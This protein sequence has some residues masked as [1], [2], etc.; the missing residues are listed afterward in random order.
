[1]ESP[2]LKEDSSTFTFKSRDSIPKKKIDIEFCTI[3]E[4][5]QGSIQSFHHKRK[6]SHA[7]P[8]AAEVMDSH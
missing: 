2:G 1:M 7:V 6:D 8:N 4:E 5:E 3:K